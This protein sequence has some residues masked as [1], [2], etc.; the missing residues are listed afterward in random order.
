MARTARKKSATGIYHVM[1]RGADRRNIFSDDEDCRR[2]L[3]TVQRVKGESRF[4]EAM[5]RL[6]AV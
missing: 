5:G 4:Q 6:R 3:E 2:F 1:L